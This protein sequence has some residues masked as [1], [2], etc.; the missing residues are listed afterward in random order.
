MNETWIWDGTDW[1]Q[2]QP[3]QSPEAR[4][5]AGMAAAGGEV[6]LFGGTTFGGPIGNPE[7]TWAWDGSAWTKLAGAGPSPRTGP[8]MAAR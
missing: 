5:F 1:T 2:E 8:A 3:A 7:G 6:V 4:S